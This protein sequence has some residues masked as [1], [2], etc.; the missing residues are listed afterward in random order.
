MT[1]HRNRKMKLSPEGIHHVARVAAFAYCRADSL[2]AASEA[3]LLIHMCAAI[4]PSIQVPEIIRAAYPTGAFSEQLTWPPFPL[5]T[6]AVAAPGPSTAKRPSKSTSSAKPSVPPAATK[7]G[8]YVPSALR[9]KRP[10]SATTSTPLPDIRSSLEPLLSPDE[11]N[12][13]E[14]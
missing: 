2:T 8:S 9:R 7:Q 1:P 11:S 5:A 13:P 6:P 12:K 10:T 4:D 3:A 14:G